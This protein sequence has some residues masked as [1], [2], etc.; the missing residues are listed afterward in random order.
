MSGA[1]DPSIRVMS[2]RVLH[3][4]IRQCR[5][6]GWSSNPSR[7]LLVQGF[8][9]AVVSEAKVDEGWEAATD[10]EGASWAPSLFCDTLSKA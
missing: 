8:P 10:D 3:G 4:P 7:I 9:D 1:Q 5:Q 2:L 6:G